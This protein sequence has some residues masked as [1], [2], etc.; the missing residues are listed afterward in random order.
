MIYKQLSGPFRVTSHTDFVGAGSTFFAIKGAQHNGADHIIR[1]VNKGAQFVVVDEACLPL[2]S[3]TIEVCREDNVSLEYVKD[4]RTAL[5][6]RAAQAYNYPA[7]QLRIIGITGTKGKT[8]TA[9]ALAHLLRCAGNRVAL[10]STVGNQINSDF[11]TASLTTEQPDYLHHFFY[12]CLQAKIEYVV[13]EIAAQAVSLS[14]VDGIFLDA[15]IFTNFSKEHGEFYATQEDYFSAKAALV[16]RR[17]PYAP[18]II[19]GDDEWCQKLEHQPDV[20]AMSLEKRSDYTVVIDGLSVDSSSFSITTPGGAMISFKTRQPGQFNVYNFVMAAAVADRLG[21]AHSDISSGIGSFGGAPGR[22]E[23]H[24]LANGA[25]VYIDY[26]HNPSSFEAIL[27]TFRPF[28]QELIVLFGAGGDRDPSKR[29]IMGSIAASYADKLFL[30]SD[31]PRSEDP[32]VIIA[33]I[34]SGISSAQQAGV[35]CMLD[36][37][38]AIRAAC[39]QAGSGAIILLLGKGPDLYQL[40]QGRKDYFNEAEV[41]N[42]FF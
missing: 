3:K 17:K 25:R 28:T 42:V 34:I 24:R 14:R 39:A 5:A 4:A 30:T 21:I 6:I 22:L 15:L 7:N 41:I 9:F 10:L 1:A 18:L 13:M 2:S 37:A 40:A 32:A 11:F 20:Y 29:P 26:A 31:N 33:Q 35:Y 36:R 16:G 27:K 23:L 8:T 19:N 12:L 38:Q